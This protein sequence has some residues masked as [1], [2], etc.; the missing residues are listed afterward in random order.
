MRWRGHG[1]PDPSDVHEHLAF[2]HAAT[3]RIGGDLEL[4]QVMTSLCETA[5][6]RVADLAA[7]YL[8]ETVLTDGEPPESPGAPADGVLCKVARHAAPDGDARRTVRALPGKVAVSEL[9]GPFAASVGSGQLVMWPDPSPDGTGSRDQDD[10]GCLLPAARSGSLVVVPLRAGRHLLGFAL[11]LRSA[12]RPGFDET[13]VLTAT[14]MADQAALGAHKALLYQREARVADALQRSMLPKHP[15]RLPGVEIAYRYLPGNPAAQVGGDWFDAVPLPGSRVAL[16]VGDVMGHGVHSAATMGQL[17]TAV[18]TLAALDPPPD[19]VLRHLDQLFEETVGQAGEQFLATCVYCVY[20]P[21]AR[22]CAIA[23]A[24]HVPPVFAY[25]DGRTELVPVPAG[26]PLGVGNVA[27]ETIEVPAPDGTLIALC[28]DGLVESRD[29]DITE[30]LDELRES[31]AK[32]S[33]PPDDL[34]ENVLR[35]LRTG[36]REDDVALLI[37]RFDGIP[38]ASVANWIMRPHAQAARHVRGLIANTLTGWGLEDQIDAASLLATE[39]V[40]NA[41]RYTTRPITMRLLRTETLLCEVTDDDHHLPVL[42]E[43]GD[44]DEA[45]RGIYLVDRLSSRWGA[46]HT[47]AGKAVWFELAL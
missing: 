38:S 39:L 27:F 29:Q 34:C 19:Q 30:G 18:R 25:A 40:T 3:V 11:L 20:D 21:V 13:A 14:L 1:R 5:V 32:V 17:R 43:P 10:V 2:L 31:L 4:T 6:P 8:Y 33:D 15:P 36:E 16:I 7:T 28:T 22:R 41:I 45:G 44:D 9:T 46:S 12:G 24:G 37:A 42:C 35:A 26:V 47:A 23:N